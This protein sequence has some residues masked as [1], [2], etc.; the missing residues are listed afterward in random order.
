[1]DAIVTHHGKSANSEFEIL[2]KADGSPHD[3]TASYA[4]GNAEK[5]SVS[6]TRVHIKGVDSGMVGLIPL[7]PPFHRDQMVQMCGLPHRPRTS[8][9]LW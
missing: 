3:L 5:N 4:K 2:W 7:C 9:R 1:M 6:A 8:P